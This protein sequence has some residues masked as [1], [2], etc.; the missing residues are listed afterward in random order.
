[1]SKKVQYILGEDGEPAF[2]VL[3]VAEYNLLL[4]GPKSP[5]P[6]RSAKSLPTTVIESIAAG[7]HPLRAIREYR[8]WSQSRLA[9]VLGTS[10][11]LIS[12]VERN[13]KTLDDAMMAAAGRALK[14]EIEQLRVPTSP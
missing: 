14:V 12:S 7:H 3:P 6:A 13:L 9:Q 11:S 4:A 1:M 5:K 2:V 10:Q 8:G